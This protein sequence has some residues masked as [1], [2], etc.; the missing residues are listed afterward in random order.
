MHSCRIQAYANVDLK[1]VLRHL[2]LRRKLCFRGDSAVIARHFIP[3][4]S[5]VPLLALLAVEQ[6]FLCFPAYSILTKLQKYW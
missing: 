3:I 5:I 1:I 4:L 6:Q 2:E